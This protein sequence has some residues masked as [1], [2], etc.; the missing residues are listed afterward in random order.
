[1]TLTQHEFSASGEPCAPD[2]DGYRFRTHDGYIIS[3]RRAKKIRD[4]ETAKE[5]EQALNEVSRARRKSDRFV[6]SSTSKRVKLGGSMM[7]SRK[8]F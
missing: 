1:M 3:A 2:L 5:R 6:E 4:A 8:K 7:S